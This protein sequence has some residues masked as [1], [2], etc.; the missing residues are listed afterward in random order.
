VKSIFS[1]EVDAFPEKVN[2]LNC[3]HISRTNPAALRVKISRVEQLELCRKCAPE[4]RK[5]YGFLSGVEL[6][7]LKQSAEQGVLGLKIGKEPRTQIEP[8]EWL[9]VYKLQ[10]NVTFLPGSS[11]KRFINS[12][13]VNSTLSN[14]G[15]MYLSYIANRYRKQWHASDAETEWIVRWGSWVVAARESS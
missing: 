4:A 14:R 3:V 11:H 5:K 7:E 12:L 15:R 2:L 9:I 1:D 13:S 10:T 6:E 8:D